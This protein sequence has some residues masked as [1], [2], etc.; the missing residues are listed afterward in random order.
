MILKNILS[1]LFIFLLNKIRVETYHINHKLIAVGLIDCKKLPAKNIHVTICQKNL[2][3]GCSVLARVSSF[4]QGNFQI[5]GNKNI[6]YSD[7][8]YVVLS[9]MITKNNGINCNFR[10][11]FPI[12]KMY[13]KYHENSRNF[14]SMGIINMRTIPFQ[15]EKCMTSRKMSIFRRSSRFKRN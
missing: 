8:A 3:G 13:L 14:F 2:I 4:C 10:S 7:K 6:F 12:P 5:S 9:Y 1:F 11:T 15:Q